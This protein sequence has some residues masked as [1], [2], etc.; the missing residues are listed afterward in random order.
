LCEAHALWPELKKLIQEGG[1]EALFDR[2]WLATIVESSDDAITS[3]NFDGI[4][5]KLER[6]RGAALWLFG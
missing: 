5:T 1:F 4:I 2:M 3:M 6:R